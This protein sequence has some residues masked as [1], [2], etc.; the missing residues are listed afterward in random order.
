MY[1]ISKVDKIRLFKYVTSVEITF[2]PW[3][4]TST[5]SQELWRRLTA[6]T[7]KVS[8]PKA[9][10]NAVMNPKAAFPLT[11]VKFVDGSSLKLDQAAKMDVD[12]LI[13]EINMAAAGIDN[14]WL[15]EGKEL[16]EDE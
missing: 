13:S 6:K 15:M 4:P 2:N 8:N 10:V 1:R 3:D 14:E 12:T 5:S 7:M 9:V 11:T 16:V